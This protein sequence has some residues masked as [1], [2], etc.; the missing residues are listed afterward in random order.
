M[1]DGQSNQL[2]EEKRSVQQRSRAMLAATVVTRGFSIDVLIRNLSRSG[3]LLESTVLPEPGTRIELRRHEHAVHAEVVWAKPGRCGVKFASQV[4]IEDWVGSQ[5]QAPATP[6]SFKDADE[7]PQSPLPASLSAKPICD[8]LEDK[9]PQRLGE[10]IAYIQRLVL[11]IEADIAS[12]PTMRYRHSASLQ[13]CRTASLLLD[14]VGKVL[15]ADDRV[16]AAERVKV[17]ELRARLLRS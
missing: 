1:W 2:A 15:L 6:L 9:L 4:V 10:E 7:R 8:G 16:K 14:A 17:A 12:N 11:A 13:H 3:A 5:A